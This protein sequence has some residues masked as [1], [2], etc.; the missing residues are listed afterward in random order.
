MARAR[1]RA[2]AVAA[3]TAMVA[4]AALAAGDDFAFMPPGGRSILE[5]I[6]NRSTDANLPEIAARRASRDEWAGWADALGLGLNPRAVE[7]FAGYAELNFP[8]DDAALS[9]L[10]TSAD[11]A[12]LPADGKDLAIAQC[13]FCHSLFSGYLMQDR[14]QTGWEST[15]KSPFHSEIPMTASERAAFVDYSVLNM[16]LKFEDVPPELRF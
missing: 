7:T 3:V 14:D 10:A 12:T 4:V 16:P 9:A 1:P 11:P 5:D 8:L 2:F 13:Q 15:F 6:L